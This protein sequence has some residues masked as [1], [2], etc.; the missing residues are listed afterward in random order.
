MVLGSWAYG[1]GMSRATRFTATVIGAIF[2]AFALLVAVYANEPFN[3]ATVFGIAGAALI[4]WVWR[5]R[6]LED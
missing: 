1:P 5:K 3:I 2:V 6:A 4:A